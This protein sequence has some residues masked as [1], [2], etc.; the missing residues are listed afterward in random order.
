MLHLVLPVD[1]DQHRGQR[2]RHRGIRKRTGVERAH[3][4]VLRQRDD[5][6]AGVA[7]VAAHQHVA[8]DGMA[9]LGQKFRRD[10]LERRHDAHAR[11]Q[12]CLRLEHGRATVG[13]LHA[14]DLRRHERHRDVDQDFS[15][16]RDLHLFERRKLRRIRHRQ[17]H[18]F[19]AP[20]RREIVGALGALHADAGV[21]R[22]GGLLRALARARADDDVM[23]GVG[24][25]QRQAGAFLAGA[26]EHG[27]LR[28]R[29]G[30]HGVSRP[31]RRAGGR[32]VGGCSGARYRRLVRRR[33]AVGRRVR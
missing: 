9:E 6:R 20:C 17:H 11:A 19:A 4:G 10:V 1:G 3:A 12:H 33:A 26:A 2:L 28:F 18:D 22:S 30:L 16:E 23:A 8:V 14:A 24:P 5:L 29:F 15:G 31:R 27:D 25:A 32:R 13:Q 21:D 7:V